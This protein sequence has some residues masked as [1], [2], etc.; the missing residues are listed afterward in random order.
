MNPI[1]GLTTKH[2]FQTDSET[3]TTLFETS[4]PTLQIIIFFAQSAQC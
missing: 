1:Q 2:P 4:L 3:E